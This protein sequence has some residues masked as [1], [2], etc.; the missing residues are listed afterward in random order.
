MELVKEFFWDIEAKEVTERKWNARRAVRALVRDG[1]KIGVLK[2]TKYNFYKCL[3]GG[4]VDENED[5]ITALR[6]EIREEVG[7]EIN[8]VDEL[9]MC[10]EFIGDINLISV[11]YVYVVDKI[12]D[13][14]QMLT[15]EEI[16]AGF[17][18]EWHTPEEVL[19]L[20]KNANAT[21]KRG[22]QQMLREKILLEYYLKNKN[23]LI[24]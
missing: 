13:T 21:D 4:G 2:S 8:V 6:R 11:S 18:L 23:V 19:D 1:D 17:V 20:I 22:G 5:L 16:N 15:E 24:A 3:P 14:K 7:C 9:G 12:K 10:L